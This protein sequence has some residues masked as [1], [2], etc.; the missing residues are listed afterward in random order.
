MLLTVVLF[1]LAVIA[2]IGL[3]VGAYFVFQP[4]GSQTAQTF[5]EDEPIT[6]APLDATWYEFEMD[7][8]SEVSYALDGVE[9][10][11][12]NVCFVRAEDIDAWYEFGDVTGVC[13]DS[14]AEGLSNTALLDSG[15]WAFAVEC[16]NEFVACEAT[17]DVWRP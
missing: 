12:F 10:D 3:G 17:A 1:V 13:W 9:E 11:H 15:R 6:I 16:L 5:Y 7:S 4:G 14:E 8:E 2:I